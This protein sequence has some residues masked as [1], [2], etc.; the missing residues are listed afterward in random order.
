MKLVLKNSIHRRHKLICWLLE[1]C[2]TNTTNATISSS[3]VA[4]YHAIEQLNYSLAAACLS[5]SDELR[6]ALRKRLYILLCVSVPTSSCV[7]GKI[8]RV[9]SHKHRNIMFQVE[10][11]QNPIESLDCLSFGPVSAVGSPMPVRNS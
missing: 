10:F 1:V 2:S 6:W 7:P 9:S 5:P 8:F 4:I 3:T 11:S